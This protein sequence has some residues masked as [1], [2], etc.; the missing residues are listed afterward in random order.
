[1]NLRLSVCLVKLGMLIPLIQLAQNQCL[2]LIVGIPMLGICQNKKLGMRIIVSST[3]MYQALFSYLS[4][5]WLGLIVPLQFVTRLSMILAMTIL[6]LTQHIDM[7]MVIFLPMC[8][9]LVV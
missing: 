8:A 3:S 9:L 2:G 6:F 4:P 5:K 1:M 7:T